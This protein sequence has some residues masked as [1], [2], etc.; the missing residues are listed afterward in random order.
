[1]TIA[2]FAADIRMDVV[3]LEVYCINI[4]NDIRPWDVLSVFS[5]DSDDDGD[6]DSGVVEEGFFDCER[7]GAI[8]SILPMRRER[9]LKQTAT[10]ARMRQ[11]TCDA[12][13]GNVLLLVQQLRS[14]IGRFVHPP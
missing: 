11:M 4:T 5:A 13:I 9:N 3:S 6:G 2:H 1:M 14:D 8:H 12:I 7:W 10:K